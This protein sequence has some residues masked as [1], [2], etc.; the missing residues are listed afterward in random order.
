VQHAQ[1]R[2]CLPLAGGFKL[3]R[4]AGCR[5][6]ACGCMGAC[7]CALS[8]RR[9]VARLQITQANL[10]VT[11]CGAAHS[12]VAS[13][14]RLR[15]QVHK[16]G[17]EVYRAAWPSRIAGFA[18]RRVCAHPRTYCGGRSAPS[19]A[20]QP[21]EGALWVCCGGGLRRRLEWASGGVVDKWWTSGGQ[22]TLCSGLQPG[23]DHPSFQRVDVLA[24]DA[25]ATDVAARP[26]L[27]RRTGCP[28]EGTRLCTSRLCTSLCS[29][30]LCTGYQNQAQAAL[31]SQACSLLRCSWQFCLQSPW[32]GRCCG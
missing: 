31:R 5:E 14:E 8:R 3:Q 24:A 13:D 23:P 30:L 2:L 25:G 11:R 6:G 18:G 21:K 1:G 29:W 27:V 28:H 17:A 15:A 9:G 20:Y 32:C 10:K 22:G 26:N 4:P 12:D 16:V 19:G 7:P